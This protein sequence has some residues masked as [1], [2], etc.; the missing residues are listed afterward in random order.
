MASIT[1]KVRSPSPS[2][3]VLLTPASFNKKAKE[4]GDHLVLHNGGALGP[5]DGF[6]RPCVCSTST[7]R[8]KWT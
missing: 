8:L 7:G 5:F 6:H 1:A 2:F 4:E 3:S